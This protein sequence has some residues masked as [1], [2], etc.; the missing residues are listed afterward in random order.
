MNKCSVLDFCFYKLH[1]FVRSNG[2]S[3]GN[4]I[5]VCFLKIVLEAKFDVANEN[6]KNLRFFFLG[7][8]TLGTADLITSEVRPSPASVRGVA[9][10]A[11]AP[12]LP[13]KTAPRNCEGV[14]A[15]R[16]L[17]SV[18]LRQRR[19]FRNIYG[20]RRRRRVA[21]NRFYQV[22]SQRTHQST[23][24]FKHFEDIEHYLEFLTAK[25]DGS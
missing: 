16:C 13:R 23:E 10:K 6:T 17:K 7:T 19:I 21:E 4:D 1:R 22:G 15:R 14:A 11:E 25:G 24:C 3:H 18:F 20:S 8:S 5:L 9:P 2:R 12:L